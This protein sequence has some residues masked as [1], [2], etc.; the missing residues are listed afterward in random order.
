MSSQ[1][2]TTM[3]SEITALLARRWRYLVNSLKSREVVWKRVGA[4]NL[5]EDIASVEA[6]LIPRLQNAYGLTYTEALEW[7]KDNESPMWG[8]VDEL[9]G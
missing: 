9:C 6:S 2:E 7:L 8:D 3:Q 1:Q 4:V 5:I